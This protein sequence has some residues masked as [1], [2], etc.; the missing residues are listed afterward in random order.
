MRHHIYLMSFFG[1]LFI[2]LISLKIHKMPILLKYKIYFLSVK[3]K[4][5]KYQQIYNNSHTKFNKLR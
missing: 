5:I 2:Y 4:K 1:N 3:I